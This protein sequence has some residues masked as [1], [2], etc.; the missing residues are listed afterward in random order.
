MNVNLAVE[1]LRD[2]KHIYNVALGETHDSDTESKNNLTE[3]IEKARAF[4]ANR[5]E[6]WDRDELKSAIQKILLDKGKFICVLGGQGTGKSLVFANMEKLNMGTVFVIDLRV[7]GINILNGLITVLKER[8]KFYL[9][10]QQKGTLKDWIATGGAVESLFTC[11]RKFGE[12]DVIMNA[13]SDGS[14]KK[15]QPVH[16]MCSE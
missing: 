15:L 2:A 10:M 4:M 6:V 8:R 7:E 16:F 9:D 1:L 5:D 14:S 12:F 3:V 13:L 11:A